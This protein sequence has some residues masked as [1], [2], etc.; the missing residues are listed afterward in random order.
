[1]KKLFEKVRFGVSIGCFS[2]VAMLYIGS[3]FAG[4]ANAF[5]G[6]K[7]GN[8]WLLTATYFIMIAEGF[9]IPTLVYKKENI[10]IS[11]KILIHII[12]GTLVFLLVSYFAGWLDAHS[13]AVYISISIGAAAFFWALYMV[14]FKFQTD[15]INRT[16]KEQNRE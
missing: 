15:R 14:V 1:M 5:I 9:S 2:F 12:A 6:Q 3:V 8:E 4:G 11:L 10:A 16:I 13:A 7:T